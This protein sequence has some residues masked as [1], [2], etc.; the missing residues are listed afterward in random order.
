MSTTGELLDGR[1]RL[2]T[3]LG[4]G[5]MSDVFRAVDEVN[6]TDVA[7]KIVRSP[8][9]EYA[10]R[11]AQEA[12]ALRRF[13]HPGLVQLFETGVNGDM[14]YLVMEFVDGPSLDQVLRQGP[15]TTTETAAIGASLAD[16]LAYAHDQGVV[17][18]DVKP[19]NILIGTDGLARLTD[20]G[21][22]RL[23]DTS[24]LTLTGTMLG[25]ATYMA[26]EQLENHAVGPS[27]DVWSLG[28]VLL[29]CLTGDRVYAGTPSEVLALRLA[30][31]VKLPDGLPVPWRLLLTGML[32]TAPEDR[33]SALDVSSMIAAP[34]FRVPWVPVVM[35]SD[36][37]TIVSDTRRS[38]G[39]QDGETSII[40]PRAAPSA[41]RA[42]PANPNRVRNTRIVAGIVL[43]LIL[44][45]VGLAFALG[46]NGPKDTTTTTMRT[47]T[48]VPPTTTT[49]LP[50]ISHSLTKMVNDVVAGQSAHAIGPQSA[51]LI[52]SGAQQAVTDLASGNA[53]QA[54]TD[55]Q[56]VAATIVTGLANSYI[57]PAYGATLQADLK[58]LAD[59]LGLSAAANPSSSTTT[60]STQ[61]SGPGNGNGNG[62]GNN[63]NG[64]GNGFGN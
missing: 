29:E 24:T 45:G 31:P 2:G 8:D 59:A 64:N 3:L 14:A 46:S 41:P 13:S 61:P 48:T 23:V 5:G 51:Q 25:T 26:P 34:A 20:F 17:H 50:S 27:A 18:R 47:T 52:S 57:T 63:G 38:R 40:A 42:A 32:A 60:T 43:A 15:L 1:Y 12:Q 22:A 6:R 36:D 49:T 39:G 9:R 10:Q 56:N 37:T 19:A 16:A 58:T 35:S 55:L 62:N 7:I 53:A 4:R 33:L 11:L 28:I 21:I 30:G 54:A 44:G